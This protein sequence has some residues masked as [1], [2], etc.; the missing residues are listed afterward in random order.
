[1]YSMKKLAKKEFL[2]SFKLIPRL[3]INLLIENARGELLLAKRAISPGK[4]LWHYPGSFLI[5]GEKIIDCLRRVAKDELGIKIDGE[6]PKLID[7][8]E[9]LDTDP[10]GHV[11]DLIYRIKIQTNITLKPTQHSQDLKFFAKLPEKIGF[12][13]REVLSQIGY[14]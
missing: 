12:N 2:Y 6:K 11:V 4:G 3:A 10:R 1:M 5:R 9:N 13:H 7:V 8:S 14:K